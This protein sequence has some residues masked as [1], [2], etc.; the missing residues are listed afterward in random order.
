MGPE[1][2]VLVPGKNSVGQ[3]FSLAGDRWTFNLST[4]TSGQPDLSPVGDVGTYTGTMV[5]G[6]PAKYVITPTCAGVFIIE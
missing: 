5:S 1:G 6:D 2:V 4:K 3:E